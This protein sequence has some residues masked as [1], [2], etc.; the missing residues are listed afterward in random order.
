MFFSKNSRF[1]DKLNDIFSVVF[2]VQFVGSIIN[3]CTLVYSLTTRKELN[4]KFFAHALL[5]QS[6]LFQIYIYC[7]AGNEVMLKVRAIKNYLKKNDV[8]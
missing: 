4:D 2:G 1:G 3:I 6:L 8:F 5:L 7:Y